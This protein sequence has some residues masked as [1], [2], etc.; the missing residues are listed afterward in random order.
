[1]ELIRK[2]RKLGNS[3]GVL[4][5]KKW[6]G[7]EV[8]ITVLNRPL[9]IRKITFKILENIL[10][11]IQGIYLISEKPHEVLAISNS[12]KKIFHYKGLKLS[13]VP[14]NQLK[15]DLQAKSDL[16]SKLEKSRIIMNKNLLPILGI[17]IEKKQVS[18]GL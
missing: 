1:M 14:L 17:K 15:K 10:S 11:D 6:L 4:L 3:S 18:L 16:K 9:N 2:T 12:I 8:K 7:Y 5:P 13:V